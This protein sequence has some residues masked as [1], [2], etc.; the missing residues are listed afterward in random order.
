MDQ[1]K[2]APLATVQRSGFGKSSISALKHRIDLKNTSAFDVDSQL[3]APCIV[4]AVTPSRRHSKTSTP[5][6]SG[7]GLSPRKGFYG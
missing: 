2:T 3:L 1:F 5:T 4:D 7:R 6:R